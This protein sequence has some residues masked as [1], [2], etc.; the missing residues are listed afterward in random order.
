MTILDNGEATAPPA[1]YTQAVA[2]DQAV[3]TVGGK[4]VAALVAVE[5]T[6]LETISP[7]GNPEF[8][9]I[10]AIIE[11]SRSRWQAEGGTSADAVRWRLALNG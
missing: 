9:A 3:V 6:G 10:L 4:P 2:A 1:E 7:G 11:R 5:N 8:L